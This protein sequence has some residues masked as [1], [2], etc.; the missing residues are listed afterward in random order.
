[1]G[2]KRPKS[3]VINN[4]IKNIEM[5]FKQTFMYIVYISEAGF[6]EICT[7]EI[8]NNKMKMFSKPWLQK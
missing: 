1:M 6:L 4:F 8:V 5:I 7:K 2:A 3:L